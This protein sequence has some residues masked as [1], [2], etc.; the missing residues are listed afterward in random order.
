MSTFV[1]AD[2]TGRRF[3]RL[4]AIDLG[5]R[6]KHNAWQWHVKCDCGT[7][8][9]VAV[10]RL[11]TGHTR[12][13]G[14]LLRGDG[15][16]FVGIPTVEQ[17]QSLLEY[18]PASG[19][20]RWKDRTRGQAKGWFKG[21]KGV[22]NYRRIWLGGRHYLSHVVAYAIMEGQWPTFE[23]DHIDRDQS[24]NRWNNLRLARHFQN[25]RNRVQSKNSTTGVLG[26]SIFR[27]KHG[28]IRYR[29]TMSLYGKRLSFGV[30][31]SI[32]EAAAARK[33]AENELWGTFA[34]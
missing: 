30:F 28:K 2:L 22:R 21:N 1:P 31:N 11:R 25:S 3:G 17:L 32:P 14:C 29:A 8:K 24:N 10:H 12:S 20:L 16:T 7:Q 9:L 13:C 5:P 18:D 15:R 34:P 26:V 19:L 23:I 4:I 6:N 27:T 33:A